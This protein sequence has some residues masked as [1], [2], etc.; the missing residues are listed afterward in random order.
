MKNEKTFELVNLHLEAYKKTLSFIPAIKETI[1]K[2][3]GKV[4]NK[5]LDTALKKIDGS[6]SCKCEYNSFMIDWY[7]DNRHIT[8][9]PDKNGYCTSLYIKDHTINILHGC[10]SSSYGDSCLEDGKILAGS[11]INQLEKS[12]EEKKKLI[13]SVIS[14]LE[15]IEELQ[16]EKEGIKKQI[17]NHNNNINWMIDSYFNLRIK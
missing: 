10:I 5:R 15:G 11:I 6:L 12:E 14:Q 16:A 13:E 7:I 9:T 2:F 3:D 17:E 1:S 8:N 4:F